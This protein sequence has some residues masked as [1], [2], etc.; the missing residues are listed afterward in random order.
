MLKPISVKKVAVIN[1]TSS[2]ETLKKERIL[3]DELPSLQKILDEMQIE[4][5]GRQ[6]GFK[7]FLENNKAILNA[8]LLID[9]S[10]DV[11][12]YGKEPFLKL[13]SLPLAILFRFIGLPVIADF[14][15]KTGTNILSDLFSA[16]SSPKL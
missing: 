6:K 1:A 7:M 9:D 3:R 14:F 4:A 12:R 13:F 5:E 16:E 8:G 2:N 11:I 15:A 10:M